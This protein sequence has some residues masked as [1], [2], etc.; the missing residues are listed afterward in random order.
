LIFLL[1]SLFAVIILVFAVFGLLMHQ[2]EISRPKRLYNKL[3]LSENLERYPLC[4][5][6]GCLILH[7]NPLFNYVFKYNPYISRPVRLL[8]FTDYFLIISS[9]ALL[10]YEWLPD[11]VRITD[12]FWFGFLVMLV[13]LVLRPKV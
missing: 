7:F 6:L 9:T 12:I 3:S 8:V 13:I 5:L 4:R 11:G 1:P 10:Y 2:T